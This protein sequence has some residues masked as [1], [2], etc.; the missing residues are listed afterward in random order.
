MKRNIQ[1]LIYVCIGVIVLSQ[2]QQ[3]INVGRFDDRFSIT[4]GKDYLFDTRI[5]ETAKIRTPARLFVCGFDLW[6]FGS[7]LFGDLDFA[8]RL[9]ESLAPPP[10]ETDI[11]LQGGLNGPCATSPR[12]SF[13]GRIL[14][15]HSES[16]KGVDVEKQSLNERFFKLG[17]SEVSSSE[18]SLHVSFGA[19]YFVS[20]TTKEQRSWILDPSK[21]P[22]SIDPRDAV[23]YVVN[24]CRT[25]RNEAA[26]EISETLDIRIH[27]N[28][29]CPKRNANFV[30]IPNEDWTGRDLYH[31]NWKLYSKYK[32]CL[33]IE[34]TATSDYVTE[35]IFLAFMGGC[36]P[37]YWGTKDVFHIFNH[38]AFIFYDFEKP[39]K[40]LKEIKTLQ[41]NRSA[42]FEKLNAP[43]LAHGN[44]TIE[45]HLSLADDVGNGSLKIQ[46]RSMMGL[47]NK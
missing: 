33:V 39:D 16:R 46:I 17:P 19:I 47:E 24:Q 37:I 4:K 21:K 28:P 43:I 25:F 13:P 31:E 22:K 9:G 36:I 20:A 8:G 44:E 14:F 3:K 40:A 12:A 35:K 11:L 1:G 26:L 23:I 41:Q 30:S 6:N 45:S 10:L 7:Q 42:Y 34:N 2:I 15:I 29:K 32:F 38:K 5:N 18:R 27:Q